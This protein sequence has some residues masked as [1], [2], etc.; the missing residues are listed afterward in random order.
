MYMIETIL[1]DK[2]M[3]CAF[4]ELTTD[5]KTRVINPGLHVMDNKAPAALKMAMTTMY[6]CFHLVPPS[7]NMTNNAERAIQTFKNH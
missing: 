1:S 4:T 7:N 3:I 6:N 2:Y 5:L